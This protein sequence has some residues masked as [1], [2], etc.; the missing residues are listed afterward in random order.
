MNV[1]PVGCSRPICGPLS[2]RPAWAPRVR[3]VQVGR[4]AMCATYS[5]NCIT[6]G[7]GDRRPGWRSSSSRGVKRAPI[8][9][10]WTFRASAATA[11]RQCV[12]AASPCCLLHHHPA[13]PAGGRHDGSNSRSRSTNARPSKPTQRRGGRSRSRGSAAAPASSPTP[14]GMAPCRTA[15]RLPCPVA[16]VQRCS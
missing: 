5:T 8:G 1:V 11:L 6:V 9:C 16:R 3:T 2:P 12:N 4:G 13:P 7:M 10:P 14:T 15:C